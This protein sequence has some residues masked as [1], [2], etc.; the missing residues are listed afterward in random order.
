MG[1]EILVSS[2]RKPENGGFG[3]PGC[4]EAS[5]G[6][7]RPHSIPP[8]PRIGGG[9]AVSSLAAAVAMA[10]FRRNGPRDPTF[11]HRPESTRLAATFDDDPMWTF[12]PGCARRVR[13][14]T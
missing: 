14:Q 1:P 2:S 7:R 13:A 12:D 9:W 6:K 8:Q 10:V 11:R 3:G 5:V 4:E